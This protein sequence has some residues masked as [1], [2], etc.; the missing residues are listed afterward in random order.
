MRILGFVSEGRFWCLLIPQ[1]PTAGEALSSRN[2][3][4]FGEEDPKPWGGK[5][6]TLGE[7]KLNPQS[8]RSKPLERENSNPWRRKIQT[9]GE[10]I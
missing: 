6:Q 10:K 2:T 3:K 8:R 9:L 7:G 1:N 5:I 4:V